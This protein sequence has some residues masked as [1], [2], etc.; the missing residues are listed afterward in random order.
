MGQKS[1]MDL[2]EVEWSRMAEES[3][4]ILLEQWPELHMNV[5]LR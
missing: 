5:S 2:V 4:W 3:Q 1:R